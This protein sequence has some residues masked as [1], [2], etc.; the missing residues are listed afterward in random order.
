MRA[1]S[2]EGQLMPLYAVVLLVACGTIVLLGQLGHLANRR[3]RARTAADAAALAGAAEGRAAAE[4]MATAN[5][6]VLDGF[7]GDGTK[8][9]VVVHIGS[10]H[11]AARAER[12]AAC[13]QMAGP[14]HLHFETCQPTSRG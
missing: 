10:T 3:A 8:V 7:S 5:G 12:G 11:A 4:A 1:R 14:Q 9:D 13:K 2:D 6:A